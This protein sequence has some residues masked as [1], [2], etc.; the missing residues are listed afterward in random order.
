MRFKNFMSTE[1]ILPMQ[2]RV[3]VKY[4]GEVIERPGIDNAQELE[5]KGYKVSF[6]LTDDEIYEL[7]YNPPLI[8]KIER[9]YS[10]C[11]HKGQCKDLAIKA[12]DLAHAAETQASGQAAQ[13]GETATSINGGPLVRNNG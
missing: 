9:M 2:R 1:Q 6:D 4:G 10:R 12:I 5:Y 8:R 3:I 13:S 11:K 7:T